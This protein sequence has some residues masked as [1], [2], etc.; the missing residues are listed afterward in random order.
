M[1]IRVIATGAQYLPRAAIVAYAP[2]MLSGETVT[3]PS[4]KDVM[5]SAGIPP[6]SAA[7]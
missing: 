7:P 5:S 6:F 3:E 1:V 2:A 4:V